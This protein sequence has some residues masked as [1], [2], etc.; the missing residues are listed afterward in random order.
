M[1]ILPSY[2]PT[3]IW[4]LALCFV[5]TVAVLA[6]R[7]LQST[8][9]SSISGAPTV[10]NLSVIQRPLL[11]NSEI[12]FF[13]ILQETVGSQYL[14]F[15]QL[16]L[17]TMI[18]TSERDQRIAAKFRNQIDRKRV[19]FVLADPATFAIHIVIELGNL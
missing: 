17:C 2:F 15:P 6:R 14:I 16:A 19:D 9:R 1:S 5:L 10:A 8:S 11:T 4:A 13:H 18:D 12:K 3:L 7:R